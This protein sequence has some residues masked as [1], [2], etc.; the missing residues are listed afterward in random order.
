MYRATREIYEAFQDAGLNCI[1]KE[2]DHSSILIAGMTGRATSFEVFF[3]SKDN[4][5]DVSLRVPDLVHY[6]PMLTTPLLHAVNKLN[7]KYRYAKFTIDEEEQTVSI[8]FDVP[9]NAQN[10]GPIALELLARAS[11]AV[12]DAYPVLIQYAGEE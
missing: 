2:L 5:N 3:I 7:C 8:A 6:D 9:L 12:E 10:T 4:D 11:R 1:V